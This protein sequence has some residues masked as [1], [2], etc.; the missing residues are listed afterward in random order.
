MNILKNTLIPTIII[1]LAAA[2]VVIAALPLAETEWAN[3]FR[4]ENELGD[5]SEPFER[6]GENAPAVLMFILP[7]VKVTIFMGVGV[8]LTTLIRRFTKSTK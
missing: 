4:V 5:S 3:S 1:L 6:E 8:L 2:L 7:L